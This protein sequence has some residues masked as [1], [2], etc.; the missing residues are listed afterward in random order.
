MRRISSH[1]NNSSRNRF[2]ESVVL[3]EQ[4]S[5]QFILDADGIRRRSAFFRGKLVICSS[6][7]PPSI[8]EAFIQSGVVALIS[9]GDSVRV[10]SRVDESLL[11]LFWRAFYSKLRGFGDVRS[12]L[13]FSQDCYPKLRDYFNIYGA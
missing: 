10:N 4:F 11:E 8:R 2:L 7:L 12:S 5:P 6:W 9:V 3:T 13:H 1:Y